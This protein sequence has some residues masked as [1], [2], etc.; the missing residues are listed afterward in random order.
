MHL[1]GGSTACSLSHKDCIITEFALILFSG[2]N[3]AIQVLVKFALR[4]FLCF[5][6]SRITTRIQ[7]CGFK[8]LRCELLRKS[9][10]E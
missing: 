10:S 3:I 6:N 9:H 4:D 8:R 5:R 2:C 1:Y 7:Q